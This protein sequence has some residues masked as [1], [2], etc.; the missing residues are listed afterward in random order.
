M[1]SQQE[2]V[3]VYLRDLILKGEFVPGER[4]AEVALAE[5]LSASRTPVRLAL[6]TLEQEGLVEQ[7]PGGGYVMRRITANEISDAI[8]V[9]GHLEGMAARLIAEHG[10]PRQLANALQEC[11]RAGDRLFEKP[12]LGIDDYA[13]YTDM[14]NRFH[15]LLVEGSGNA[16]LIRAIEV[17]NRLPFA[18]ASAMLPMQSALEE[19]RQWLFLAHQQHHS[20]VKAMLK[21][22]GTR[23]Q[24]IATEH[25][26]IAQSNLTFALERPEVFRKLAP[27]LHLV[28]EAVL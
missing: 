9:R 22:E 16:A 2:R 24:A 19:G 15:K 4:L 27:A 23:A 28:T 13:A 21:G 5:R 12:A 3:L 11:L 18:A 26:Q 7:S 6:T 8:A 10:V 17:N 20:L 1:E 25:V 14:N